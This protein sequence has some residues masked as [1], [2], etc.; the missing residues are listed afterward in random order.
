M[1]REEKKESLQSEEIRMVD[2]RDPTERRVEIDEGLQAPLFARQP[3]ENYDDA[4]GRPRSPL[5]LPHRPIEPTPSS[6]H[7]HPQERRRAS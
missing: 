6:P 7:P 1:K 3:R 2:E 5:R 4:I